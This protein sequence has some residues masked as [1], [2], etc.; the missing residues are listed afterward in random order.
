MLDG[1]AERLS[2][3]FTFGAVLLPPKP[4]LRRGLFSDWRRLEFA[5][6]EVK[7]PA[8]L[9]GFE[10]T[11][12][13]P[14]S[15]DPDPRRCRNASDHFFRMEVK[16]GVLESFGDVPPEPAGDDSVTDSEED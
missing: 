5:S 4:Q 2:E 11:T 10:P 15:E 1:R 9:N 6:C 14:L 12:V 16:L 3:T 7:E 13:Q 8:F